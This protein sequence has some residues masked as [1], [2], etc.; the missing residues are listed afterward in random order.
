MAIETLVEIP[1]LSPLDQYNQQLVQNVHPPEWVNPAPKPCYDMVVIGAGTA[2]LICAAGAAGLGATVALVEKSLMGGDCL[3]VGC[4]PSKALLRAARA[5][6]DVREA[7]SFGVRLRGSVEVDFAAVM[8]RLRKLRA[9]LSGHDSAQRFRDLG[10]DV[11]IGEGHF[12]DRRSI[13]VGSQVLRFSKAVIA[14]GARAVDLPIPG[15]AKAGYLT[16]ENVFCLT[17]RPARLAVIGGGPI[18]CELA[19][20]FSRLGSQVFLLEQQRQ[21]LPREDRDAAAIIEKSLVHDGVTINCCCHIKAVMVRDGRKYLALECP[22]SSG[23]LCVDEI[24]IGVGREPNVEGLNLE[25]AGVG[26]DKRGVQVDDCLRTSNRRIYAAGDIC[27]PFKFT[28]AADAMARIVIQNALFLGRKRAGSQTIP[29]CTYTDPEV[30]H[31][32]LYSADAEKLGLAVD[33]VSVPLEEVDRAVLDSETAGFLKVHVQKGSGRILGATLV[34]RHAGDILSEIT[35][36]MQAKMPLG[37]LASVIHPYPTQAV[38]I[39]QAADAYIR[40]RLTPQVKK[41]LGLILKITRW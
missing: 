14:T 21:L 27:S 9:D 20:A 30:A 13:G 40:R 34:A 33:T 25:A 16:N 8:E 3:N 24:L 22:D 36:A 18:G 4:V 35:L 2:G 12:I 38:V 29:W 15:L 32:G 5:C 19:Q 31:V 37:K 6:H 41:L 11:F 17:S 10:V 28:H 1:S 23:E 26:Y 39:K 7:G